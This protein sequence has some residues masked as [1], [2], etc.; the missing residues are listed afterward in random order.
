MNWYIKKVSAI[1]LAR[2]IVLTLSQGDPVKED[3]PVKFNYCSTSLVALG[4]PAHIGLEVNACEDP[5][6]EGAPVYKNSGM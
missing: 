6:D 5:R 1:Y 4:I 3:T 2:S